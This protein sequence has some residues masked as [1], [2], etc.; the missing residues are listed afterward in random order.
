MARATND[1]RAVRRVLGDAVM[2][3]ANTIIFFF[4]AF[5]IMFKIDAKLTLLALIPFPLMTFLTRELGLRV[6]KRFEQIQEGYS[7]LSVKVQENLAGVRVVKAYNLEKNEVAD[8]TNLNRDFVERN[9]KLQLG[10]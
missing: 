10:R 4:M 9:R 7:T 6:H 5:I 3:A 2:Y 1:L 8:F